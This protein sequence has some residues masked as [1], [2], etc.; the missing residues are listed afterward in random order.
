MTDVQA[1]LIFR[2]IES[3]ITLVPAPGRFDSYINSLP[4]GAVATAV[5]L[6]KNA[7]G[8]FML[9]YQTITIAANAE[10]V[11]LPEEV[12]QAQVDAFIAGIQ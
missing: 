4:E 12:T 5:L 9:G 8:N 2:D 11:L 6:G 1:L 3:V 10:Y 7:A